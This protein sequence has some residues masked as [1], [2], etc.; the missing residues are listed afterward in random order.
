MQGQQQQR[1]CKTDREHQQ[2]GALVMCEENRENE[3]NLNLS[4]LLQKWKEKRSLSAERA[5]AIREEI[6]RTELTAA[7][8]SVFK[9]E[10]LAEAGQEEADEADEANEADKDL[11]YEWWL[12]LYQKTTIDSINRMNAGYHSLYKTA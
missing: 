10:S 2:E 9:P 5:E 1:I 8:A 3:T 6:I 11:G 7:T 4:E 12:D